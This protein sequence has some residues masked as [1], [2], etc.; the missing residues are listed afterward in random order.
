MVVFLLLLLNEAN[1][2]DEINLNL[3]TTKTKTKTKTKTIP[4]RFSHSAYGALSN[5]PTRPF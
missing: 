4:G 3:G 2:V 1:L 5:R